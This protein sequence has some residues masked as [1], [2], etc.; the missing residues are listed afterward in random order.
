MKRGKKE[1][2]EDMESRWGG[3]K[4]G[5]RKG[6]VK[7]NRDTCPKFACSN[8][9][10]LFKLKLV[11]ACEL[12]CPSKHTHVQAWTANFGQATKWRQR[13]EGECY[14]NSWTPVLLPKKRCLLCSFTEILWQVWQV[15]QVRPVRV[16]HTYRPHH[17]Y[18]NSAGHLKAC[19]FTEMWTYL[20]ES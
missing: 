11:H 6:I 10:M 9:H 15:W 18:Q 4:W 14:T 8:L 16:F 17:T 5:G 19:S 20:S 1:L 3:E 2:R 13:G 7:K 12:N